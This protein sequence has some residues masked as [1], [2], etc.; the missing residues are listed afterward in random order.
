MWPPGGGRAD[1]C[2]QAHAVAPGAGVEGRAVQHGGLTVRRPLSQSAKR[3]KFCINVDRARKQI[4]DKRTFGCS[5]ICV[6]KAGSRISY[7]Y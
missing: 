1:V 5:R 3:N 7:R 4:L 2:P 6:L